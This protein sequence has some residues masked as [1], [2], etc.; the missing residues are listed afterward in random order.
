MMDVMLAVMVAEALAISGLVTM[1]KKPQIVIGK[2]KEGGMPMLKAE[3]LIQGLN[4]LAALLGNHQIWT[5]RARAHSASSAR[6][7]ATPLAWFLYISYRI[8][9]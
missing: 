6:Q 5:M 8:W 3:C 2:T 4:W 9:W 7:L 1:L